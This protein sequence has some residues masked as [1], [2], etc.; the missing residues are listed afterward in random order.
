M[1]RLPLWTVI[2]ATIAAGVLVS[3]MPETAR[4]AAATLK[5]QI[6]D[7]GAMTNADIGA[8]V[9]NMGT[10]RTKTLAVTPSGTVG[11][12]SG[13]VPKHM[14]LDSD[15]IQYVVSGSGTFWLGDKQ[16]D[17]HPGDLIIIP[18]GT[19]HAGSHPSSGDFKVIVIKLPPA[20]PGD[21]HM[22][23]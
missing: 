3:Q 2:P 23:K 21:M 4:A 8:I 19:P 14:H 22:V 5:P 6:I 16:R 10:L 13:D 7:V 12:Q 15:E 18:K 11:V 9:P 20:V 1:S 17:I